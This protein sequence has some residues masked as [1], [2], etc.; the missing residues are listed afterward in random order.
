M[1]WTHPLLDRQCYKS[2]RS[3]KRLTPRLSCSLFC[4]LS[5]PSA[6]KYFSLREHGKAREKN[7]KLWDL[8][9]SYATDKYR[10]MRQR[11]RERERERERALLPLSHLIV[12]YCT[13]GIRSAALRISFVKWNFSKSW[14][15][16]HARTL[17]AKG[18]GQYHGKSYAKYPKS[19]AF[20][21]IYI[22]I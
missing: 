1:R 12:C 15:R 3:H 4:L 11:E 7:L 17:I 9:Y 19:K 18:F 6:K 21:Q 13:Y 20:L 2:L 14:K 8:R 22:Y 10:Y 5:R 16:V